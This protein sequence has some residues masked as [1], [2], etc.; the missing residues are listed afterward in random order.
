MEGVTLTAAEVTRVR[1]VLYLNGLRGPDLDDAMQDVNLRLLENATHVEHRG[2]WSCAVATRVA[3]DRHRSSRRRG[4]AFERLRL[5]RNELH[6]DPDL[7]LKHSVR[8][9]L[10]RLDPDLRATVVLRYYADLQVG[11]IADLLH[12]AEG[13]VKSRLHRAAAILRH[14]LGSDR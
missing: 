10:R 8:A 2:A 5:H 12:V 13:T 6:D 7:A 3:L 4:A 9:A 14:E 1:A 11:E